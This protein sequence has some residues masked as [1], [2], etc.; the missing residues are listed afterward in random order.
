MVDAGV[1]MVNAFNIDGIDPAPLFL[2]ALDLSL[3]IIAFTDYPDMAMNFNFLTGPT[4]G[5]LRDRYS[6]WLGRELPLMVNHSSTE[7]NL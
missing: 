5:I 1:K 3:M 7:E 2:P 6:R 4:H